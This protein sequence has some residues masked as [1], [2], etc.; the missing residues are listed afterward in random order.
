MANFKFDMLPATDRIAARRALSDITASATAQGVWLGEALRAMS[1]SLDS[2][3]DARLIEETADGHSVKFAPPSTGALAD[4]EARSSIA[5]WLSAALE[6]FVIPEA[7]AAEPPVFTVPEPGADPARMPRKSRG[8]AARERF[9]RHPAA[10][11]L[12]ADV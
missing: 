7:A 4:A 3:Q 1:A 11:G 2:A 9:R 6:D 10:G 8:R 12:P 5:A